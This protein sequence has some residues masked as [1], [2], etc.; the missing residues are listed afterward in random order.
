MKKSF[1]NRVFAGVLTCAL[2]ITGSNIPSRGA[3]A[4]EDTDEN[5]SFTEVLG[6]D[7]LSDLQFEWDDTSNIGEEHTV[8]LSSGETITIKDNGDMREDVSAQELADTEMGTGINLGNTMEAVWSIDQKNSVTGSD[9]DKAWSQP[10][11]TRAYIDAI[12]SYGINT[13]RIPVA[14]SNGDVDDGTYTIRGDL[15]DRVETIVNYALDDGMYVIINDHWD[16][17][18][19]GQFGAC[20]KDEDGNK[21]A[22][23]ETRAAAWTRYE[24]YWTQI[25]ERFK[26]YSDHLI[27]EGANEELGDRL[28]DGICIN[29]SA[30]GYAKPDNAGSDVVV[31]GGNLTTDELYQTVNKINQKF[32]DVVRGT[33]GNN[34]KRFLLIPGYNTDFTATA[35]ERYQMPTDLEE[36]D[37]DRLFLSVHYYMPGDFCLNASGAE[38]TQEDQDDMIDYFDELSRFSDEG[39]GI[40]IGEC[41]VCEPSGV[42]GSVTQWLYDTFSEAQIYSAVPVLWETGAYFDRTECT[43]NYRDIATFYNTVNGAEGAVTSER[44]TGGAVVESNTSLTVPDYIDLSVWG[45][46]GLHAYL[47]Y[48]TSTWDYRDSYSPARSMSKGSH[49]WE[50]VQASGVEIT[51]ET[52]A[53]TD[54]LMTK[55]G[56]YT[57][58][59]EGLDLSGANYFNMLGVSTDIDSKV[60]PDIT[61]SDA[62][63]KI[64]GKEV[65]EDSFDMIVKTDNQ[66]YTF[67]AINKYD[68]TLDQE[69]YPLGELNANE[70]LALPTK[71]IEITFTISGIETVLEDIEDGTYIYPETDTTTPP[72]ITEAIATEEPVISEEPTAE[73]VVSVAPVITAAPSQ[74]TSAPSVVA[75]D[76]AVT[77]TEEKTSNKTV[78]VSGAKYTVT[79]TDKKTVEYK[80]PTNTKKTSVTVPSQVTIEGTKY[81]VTSI[82][83]NAFKNNKKLRS[84]TIGSHV[85]KIGAGAFQGCSN[86]KKIIVKSKK[87]T[88]IGAKAFKGIQKKAVFTVPKAKYKAYKKLLKSKTGFKKKTMKIKKK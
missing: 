33:G 49:S 82:A 43:M 56:E 13:L 52:S 72:Q 67:T 84:V 12:H 32:V 88:S 3:L 42:S 5:T 20:V 27:F 68:K 24:R 19:W 4:A 38:Y 77:A 70:K 60:Y 30:K 80:A 66:Y 65:T 45:T 34:T 1:V 47:Y 29:G 25:A 44:D 37:T 71:S 2:V 39:Y 75:S 15:L 6:A 53:V 28:N 22:D 36:N 59:L 79:D 54:V 74:V 35:D 10:E 48:Q 40:I 9:F 8:T 14:W 58:K 17:Q 50:Y 62:T 85:K 64:D 46:A 69:D 23:E 31:V 73:P 51:K 78:S 57:V 21:V 7:D 18:W 86:L 55:D 41:G 61:V 63:V 11:T 87:L 83:K 26:G 16:N 81:Q 76:T